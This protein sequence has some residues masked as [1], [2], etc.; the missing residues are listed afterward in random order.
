MHPHYTMSSTMRKSISAGGMFGGLQRKVDTALSGL[1]ISELTLGYEYMLY[2][3][4]FAA[5]RSCQETALKGVQP[6]RRSSQCSMSALSY[7]PAQHL[8]LF[9]MYRLLGI[10]AKAGSSGAKVAPMYNFSLL[11]QDIFPSF[12]RLFCSNFTGELVI[13][14]V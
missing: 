12:R 7:T 6:I 14:V 10:S 4:K 5:Q 11:S 3:G 9:S 1:A 13:L 8:T 2:D